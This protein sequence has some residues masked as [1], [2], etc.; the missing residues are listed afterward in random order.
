M[1]GAPDG[2]TNYLI[3][4]KGGNTAQGIRLDLNVES[5][6]YLLLEKMG[7]LSVRQEKDQAR[8]RSQA[9]S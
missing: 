3:W 4:E 9:S 1:M 5:L 2:Q 7:L 6:G 8:N